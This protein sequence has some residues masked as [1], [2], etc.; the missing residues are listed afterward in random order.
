MNTSFAPIQKPTASVETQTDESSNIR[1][2]A[3]T[4]T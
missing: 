4:D 2:Y 3:E 1:Q